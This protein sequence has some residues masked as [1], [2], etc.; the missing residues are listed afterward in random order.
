M[1]VQS[2]FILDLH[3]L[4]FDSLKTRGN[5]ATGSRVTYSIFVNPAGDPSVDGL[6]GD[7]D[8]VTNLAHDHFAI[9]Q[10]GAESTGGSFTTGRWSA[11]PVDLSGN[12]GL[13]GSNRLAIRIYGSDGGSADQDFGIDNLILNGQV[14]AIPEPTSLGWMLLGAAVLTCRRRR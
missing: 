2:G 6:V 4:S 5:N 13:T 10:S 9:G 8:F 7:V 12:Q 3:S 1:T 14:T 11:G